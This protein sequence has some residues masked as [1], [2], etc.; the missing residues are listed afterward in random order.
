M[1][2]RNNTNARII[3]VNQ[4]PQIDSH[5]TA[6]VYVDTEIDQSS[7]VRNNQDNDFN[8]NNL[9]KINSITLN[10]QA[11]KDNQVLT[12]AY[13]DQFH[14]ENERSRRNLGIDFYNKSSDI[15]KNIQDNDVKV[16]KIT[17]LD[18]IASNRN[19]SFDNEVSNKKY[20][21]DELDKNIIVRF[22]RTL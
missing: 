19:P 20:I 3:Q 22:K 15:V 4:W 10:T 8:N 1:N 17:N 18:S 21:D 14:Q 7:L 13:V 9:T 5:L 11:F 12:K 16:K 2:D 6:K